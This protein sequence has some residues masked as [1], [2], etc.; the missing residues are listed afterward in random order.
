MVVRVADWQETCRRQ[1]VPT[2]RNADSVQCDSLPSLYVVSNIII[3]THLPLAQ[4]SLHGGLSLLLHLLFLGYNLHSK[5][6]VNDGGA[7]GSNVEEGK[8]FDR[9]F[10]AAQMDIDVGE[11]QLFY[12]HPPCLHL[13]TLFCNPMEIFG[14]IPDDWRV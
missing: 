9:Y 6:G 3:P 12:P 13:V 8:P 5:A 4:F 11:S 10:V 7:G 2:L 14:M 1:D